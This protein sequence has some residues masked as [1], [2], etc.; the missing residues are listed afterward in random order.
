MNATLDA[1]RDVRSRASACLE[2]VREIVR[3][4]DDPDRLDGRPLGMRRGELTDRLVRDEQRKIA[5][6]AADFAGKRQLLALIDSVARGAFEGWRRHE[7]D[8][9]T[10]H[11]WC[12]WCGDALS[13]WDRTFL[14][15]S[16][17]SFPDDPDVGVAQLRIE[18]PGAKIASLAFDNDFRN[19][20]DVAGG[21]LDIEH[22]RAARVLLTSV[23]TAAFAE[24]PAD[25][26]AGPPSTASSAVSDEAACPTGHSQKNAKKPSRHKWC[27]AAQDC[28]DAYKRFVASENTKAARNRRRVTLQ[29][30][31]LKHASNSPG[32]ASG[33][34]LYK[35]LTE[36]R[37]IWDETGRYRN[38][39]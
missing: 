2:G 30:F 15:A 14:I 27:K 28:A 1:L 35:K 5:A 31:C 7:W 11:A 12:L 23:G 37:S 36:N 39:R 10:A 22:E 13:R 17:S 8:A 16:E 38:L 19:R 20:L 6:A 9:W 34:T 18:M 24:L 21:A 29:D 4:S 25:G 33:T 3:C 26:S 32:G